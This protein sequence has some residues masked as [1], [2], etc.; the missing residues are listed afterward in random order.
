MPEQ[1]I[2]RP[3]QCPDHRPDPPPLHEPSLAS[4]LPDGPG[5]PEDV[6]QLRRAPNGDLTAERAELD[7][8]DVVW[9]IDR[10][11]SHALILRGA[12]SLHNPSF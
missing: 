6:C 9:N 2:C 12:I 5:T 11:L 7:R 3:L 4:W 8:S 10:S 1:R